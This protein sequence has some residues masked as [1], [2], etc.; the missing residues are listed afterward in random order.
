[1]ELLLIFYITLSEL[2]LTKLLNHFYDCCLALKCSEL[3]KLASVVRAQFTLQCLDNYCK[4]F[5]EY[6]PD[7]KIESPNEFRIISGEKKNFF[8]KKFF[9]ER[10]KNFSH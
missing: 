1:M 3:L 9:V 5:C 4:K 10:I 2:L 7:G 8:G 6:H